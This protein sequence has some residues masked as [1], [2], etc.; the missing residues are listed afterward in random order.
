MRGLLAFVGAVLVCV[1]WLGAPSADGA[2]GRATG[3]AEESVLVPPVV[4]IPDGVAFASPGCE[5]CP[6]GCVGDQ[7][8][9]PSSAPVS[10]GTCEDCPVSAPVSS[11][12]TAQRRPGVFPNVRSRVRGWRPFGW[13]RPRSRR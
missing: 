2:T 4:S 10:G 5:N 3:P 6:G 7:C 11:V 9:L 1:A 13:L 12:A 8:P